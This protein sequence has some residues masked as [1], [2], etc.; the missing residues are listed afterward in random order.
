MATN[1]GDFVREVSLSDLYWR[2]H[3]V[4]AGRPPYWEVEV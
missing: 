3:F 4:S 1:A 2:E